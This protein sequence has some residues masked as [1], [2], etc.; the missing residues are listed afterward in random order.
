VELFF[1]SLLRPQSAGGIEVS[2][3]MDNGGGELPEM[4]KQ[5]A[6]E[7]WT[8]I[9]AQDVLGEEWARLEDELKNLAKQ[10]DYP[11][12][13]ARIAVAFPPEMKREIDSLFY[14]YLP[15]KEPCGFDVLVHADFLLNSSRKSIEVDN[16][17]YNRRLMEVAAK[18]FVEALRKQ[19]HLVQRPD[20]ARFLSPSG[21][22]KESRSN[23]EF[24]T[25]LGVK[26][27]GNLGLKRFAPEV[28]IEGATTRDTAAKDLLES[29][30]PYQTSWRW[31]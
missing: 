8:L 11:L 4:K 19:Q 20:F 9:S 3:A 7:P 22:A 12:T 14:C 31:H 26:W 21:T 2:V 27:V 24:D 16:N 17:M 10:F 18:V 13:D 30:I 25:D 6:P 29:R 28:K 15:T 1:V 23:V 5:I